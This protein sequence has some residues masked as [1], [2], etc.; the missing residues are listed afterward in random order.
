MS[1]YE[2]PPLDY[3]EPPLPDFDDWAPPMDAYDEPP[4][5]DLDY[6]YTLEPEPYLPPPADEDF[7][8]IPDDFVP[9]GGIALPDFPPPEQDGLQGF[10]TPEPEDENWSWHDARLIGIDHGDDAGENRYEVGA[11]DL[12][13]DAETGDLGGQYLPI[14]TFGDD[15]P[16][17]AYYNNLQEHIHNDSLTSHALREFAETPLG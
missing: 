6:D 12:Y 2:P 10:E 15:A 11:I 16:A 5:L 7:I 4:P 3:D 8:P 9:E 17:L 14:A 1:D 13:A